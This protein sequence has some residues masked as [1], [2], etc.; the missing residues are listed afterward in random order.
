MK[1]ES[2]VKLSNIYSPVLSDVVIAEN[3]DPFVMLTLT[4]ERPVPL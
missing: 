2:P 1:Y 3:P 4:P